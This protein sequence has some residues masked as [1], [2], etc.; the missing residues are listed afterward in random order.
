MRRA[1]VV[2]CASLLVVGACSA[3]H[4]H[5]DAASASQAPVAAA[6]V[7]ISGQASDSSMLPT[8]AQFAELREQ[9][10]ALRR[11][12]AELRAKSARAPAS[13][14]DASTERDLRAARSAALAEAGQA[15]RL[16]VVA[17][18]SAFR[19]EPADLRWGTSMNATVRN[20][21]VGPGGD[22]AAQLGS[23][24]CRSQT[25]RVELAGEASGASPQDL[26]MLVGR[27]GQSLPH[28]EFGQVDHGDGRPVTVLYL[29]R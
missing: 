5:A 22:S 23:I 12:L 9:V 13:G 20:A 17:A 28:A 10:S 29:T 7:A 4:D 16:R 24:E 19:A 18:E 3:S 15:E 8:A 21:L 26:L 14:P 6:S 27:L 2:V 25:C 11:D 1:V